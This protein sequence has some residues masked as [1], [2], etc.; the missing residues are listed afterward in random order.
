VF[1]VR[2][3]L[4]VRIF[5]LDE[6][7][8]SNEVSGFPTTFVF[9]PS[10]TIS[11]TCGVCVCACVCVSRRIIFRAEN[12]KMQALGC[13]EI[14]VPVYQTKRH[15]VTE[16]SSLDSQRCDKLTTHV[17]SSQ[18]GTLQVTE[19]TSGSFVKFQHRACLVCGLG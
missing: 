4:L 2:Y 11:Y 19:G 7:Q 1:S 10:S 9:A 18:S 14:L 13:N 16:E 8:C 12:L 17:C 6:H 15:H 5:D 3:E